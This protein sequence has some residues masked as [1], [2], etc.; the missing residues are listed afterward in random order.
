MT[1]EKFLADDSPPPLDRDEIREAS[2]CNLSRGCSVLS[3]C[4][5]RAYL[6]FTRRNIQGR[7]KTWVRIKQQLGIAA[8]GVWQLGCQA[9]SA[10]G[11]PSG[12]LVCSFLS[13]R[14]LTGSYASM[15]AFT[16]VELSALEIN[17]D[18]SAGQLGQSQGFDLRDTACKRQ[19]PRVLISHSFRGSHSALQ[20]L[21]CRIT[22]V[23]LVA[24]AA[25]GPEGAR[26]PGPGVPGGAPR[27]HPVSPPPA[28]PPGARPHWRLPAVP[29]ALP[30]YPIR[31]SGVLLHVWSRLIRVSGML[32]HVWSRLIRV[33]GVLLHVWS[34]LV[35]ARP[36]ASVSRTSPHSRQLRVV[37][38]PAQTRRVSYPI[39]DRW[40]L[41]P[42]HKSAHAVMTAQTDA[43]LQWAE[44]EKKSLRVHTL[45]AVIATLVCTACKVPCL[46]ALSVQRYLFRLVALAAVPAR[47][48]CPSP[49]LPACSTPGPGASGLQVWP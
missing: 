19:I 47:M 44:V 37:A 6:D 13:D 5:V 12:T 25:G 2:Q 1:P 26:S 46:S 45:L 35:R 43:H 14:G 16:D 31:V 7:R 20:K 49:S 21:Q 23:C 8:S 9:G 34:C 36:H 22:L 39:M 33:S 42:N 10:T 11:M 24:G 40:H 41:T 32:L 48:H 4:A 38:C 27:L 3:G 28:R 18:S 17:G 30:V 15:Q 29:A